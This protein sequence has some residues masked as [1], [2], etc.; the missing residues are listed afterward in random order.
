MIVDCT[1]YFT[2]DVFLAA[3]LHALFCL[4][5]PGAVAEIFNFLCLYLAED[6]EKKVPEQGSLLRKWICQL[7][8]YSSDKNLNTR[9]AAWNALEHFLKQSPQQHLHAAL[10]QAD[11]QE[12][13]LHLFS[14]RNALNPP[15]CEPS[16]LSSSKDCASDSL[17]VF[18]PITLRPKL[19]EGEAKH[20]NV[21]RKQ[22]TI[23]LQ[24]QQSI[25]LQ[26]RE[27]PLQESVGAKHSPV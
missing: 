19:Q 8:N 6:G 16:S 3:C 25:C 22:N 14:T 27:T 2:P 4:K 1:T 26:I 11:P 20:Q 18:H 13:V 5:T 24:K 21:D 17:N 15:S 10:S 23:G 9:Q 7:C 12:Q